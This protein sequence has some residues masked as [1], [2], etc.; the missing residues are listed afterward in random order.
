MAFCQ[1]PFHVYD[2][3]ADSLQQFSTGHFCVGQGPP[4]G[5]RAQPSLHRCCKLINVY[6]SGIN[7]D[8]LCPR[9][10]G[11]PPLGCKN[12]IPNI[13]YSNS[14]QNVKQFSNHF[15]VF[16]LHILE[17]FLFEANGHRIGTERIYDSSSGVNKS[18]KN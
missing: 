4:T 16:T 2:E 3:V 10:S 11:P 6:L 9:P 18:I 7:S 13:N 5:F 15:M 8:E 17:K 12:N 14:G 1:G